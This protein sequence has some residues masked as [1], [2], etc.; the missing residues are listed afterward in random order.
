MKKA[1]LALFGR[2]SAENSGESR[3]WELYSDLVNCDDDSENL[4]EEDLYKAAQYMQRST[5]AFMQSEKDWFK[6][7]A[8]I[9]LGLELAMKYMSGKFRTIILEIFGRLTTKRI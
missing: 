7:S 3:I 5:A 4:S 9:K 1:A 2:L 6:T 8:K